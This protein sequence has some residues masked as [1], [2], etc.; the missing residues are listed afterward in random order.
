MDA[1][2]AAFADLAQHC[3]VRQRHSTVLYY[4]ISAINASEL[5][6]QGLR[7]AIPV[8]LPEQLLDVVAAGSL[9]RAQSEVIVR[10]V[11]AVEGG[12]DHIPDVAA[13]GVEAKFEL[14]V[15][16][17]AG[18][19]QSVGL[20]AWGGEP[21]GHR[22]VVVVV[23]Q[24]VLLQR[25]PPQLLEQP[26]RDGRLSVLETVQYAVDIFVAEVWQLFQQGGVDELL[27]PL[28]GGSNLL[29]HG[30]DIGDC[31]RGELRSALDVPDCIG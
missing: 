9:Y 1:G 28:V 10:G 12:L 31:L 22:L 13:N 16:A 21:V 23:D 5:L 17:A 4:G 18:V 20:V 8:E 2:V 25:A 3:E 7:L 19:Q 14:V 15:V 6:E 30:V 27:V 11:G 26:F 24:V 29:L